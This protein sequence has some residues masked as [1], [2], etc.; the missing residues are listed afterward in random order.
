MELPLQLVVEDVELSVADD[1]VAHTIDVED[2]AL[3]RE[4]ICIVLNSFVYHK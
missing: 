3:E 1:A 2:V 4:I